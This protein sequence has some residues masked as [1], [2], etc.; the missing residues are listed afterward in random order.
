MKL[1][2]EQGKQKT[3]GVKP[4]ELFNYFSPVTFISFWEP[5]IIDIITIVR[6]PNSYVPWTESAN[7]LP[8]GKLT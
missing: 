6:P 2:A 7:D 3:L 8:S 1:A 5:C 4:L